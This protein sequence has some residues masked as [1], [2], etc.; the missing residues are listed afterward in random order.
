MTNH[1][2][3]RPHVVFGFHGCAKG[4]GHEYL[5]GATMTP[6]QNAYDWLGTG[7]YFWEADPSRAMKWAI[8]A[9]ERHASDGVKRAPDKTVRDPYVL[10]AV[11]SYCDCLDLTTFQG[12]AIVKD[13]YRGLLKKLAE[14]HD[15]V[16][17]NVGGVELKGRYLDCAVINHTC[18]EYLKKRR[19]DFHT[20]RAVFLE[21]DVLYVNA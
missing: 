9:R 12:V 17:E 20:V 1:T 8:D 10:G 14:I 2:A 21:G 15:P 19:L 18:T 7:Y 11:I 5:R 6:A 16:P 13:G 4:G 3:V